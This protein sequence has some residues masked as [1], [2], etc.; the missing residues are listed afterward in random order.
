MSSFLPLPFRLAALIDSQRR[1]ALFVCFAEEVV[2]KESGKPY[3]YN[4]VTG[5]TQWQKPMAY[6]AGGGG[7]QMAAA[8]T[9]LRSKCLLSGL[10]R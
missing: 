7:A 8:G 10:L 1:L 6:S 9:G 3:Y 2:D 5:V 4:S